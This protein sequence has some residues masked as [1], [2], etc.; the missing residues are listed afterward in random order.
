MYYKEGIFV[1][2]RYYDTKNVEPLFPFGHGLSYTEFKYSNL[3]I[4]P[5]K[6]KLGGTIKVNLEIENIGKYEGKE[7][8]QLYIRDVESSLER[9]FKELKEFKKINLKPGE[10]KNVQFE[11]KQDALSFYDPSQNGWVAEPGEFEILIGSSSEDIRL[12]GQ[13]ALVR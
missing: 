13:F 2:Y 1:G 5:E 10:K 3:K 9:P 4:N 8:I 7:V 6:V 12:K 11:L